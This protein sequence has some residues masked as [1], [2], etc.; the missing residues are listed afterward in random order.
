MGLRGQKE[1][2][3][4][5]GS[6]IGS[7][8]ICNDPAQPCRYCP[9]RA[10]G[11]LTALKRV[12]KVERSPYLYSARKFLPYPM[13]DVTHHLFS[14]VL[15]TK[16]TT[17]SQL[18]TWYTHYSSNIHTTFHQITQNTPNTCMQCPSFCPVIFLGNL[19]PKLNIEPHLVA[20]FLLDYGLSPNPQS[21]GF[22]IPILHI[23]PPS[24]DGYPNPSSLGIC[25]PML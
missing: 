10:Q 7:D 1:Q 21:L 11:A 17:I 5:S 9:L 25:I 16:H 3:P 2:T 18:I 6:G 24:G 8:T 20:M 12:Y 22:H 14:Y 15:I 13:W 23:K 19:I 4:T